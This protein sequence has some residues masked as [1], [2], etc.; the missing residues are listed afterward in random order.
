M[1]TFLYILFCGLVFISCSKEL[2]FAMFTE[3]VFAAEP[4]CNSPE[5]NDLQIL[6]CS[7]QIGVMSQHRSVGCFENRWKIGEWVTLMNECRK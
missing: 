3:K 2:D 5:P 4:G 1:K 6:T 7:D